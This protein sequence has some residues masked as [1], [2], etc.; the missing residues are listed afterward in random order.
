MDRLRHGAERVATT[1]GSTALVRMPRSPL[2]PRRP[3]HARPPPVR[4]GAFSHSFPR[5]S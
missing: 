4:A 1:P 5:L 3:L 2:H